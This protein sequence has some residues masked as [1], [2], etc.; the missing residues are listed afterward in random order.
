MYAQLIGTPGDTLLALVRHA[1]IGQDREVERLQAESGADAGAVRALLEGEHLPTTGDADV[2]D[3]IARAAGIAPQALGYQAAMT[4]AADGEQA[5]GG[6]RF[7]MSTASSDRYKD[8]LLQNWDVTN[9]MKAPVCPWMHNYW[10][11][12][13]GKWTD[14]AVSGAGESRSLKGT[15]IFDDDPE[16]EFAQKVASQYRRGFLGAVSVGF[17]PGKYTRR[18]SLDEDDPLFSK[19]GTIFD[20]LVLLEASAVTVPGN[21]EA[22]AIGRSMLGVRHSAPPVPPLDMSWLQAPE[23]ERAWL[24]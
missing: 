18:Y 11:L 12:P 4:R 20:D 17:L 14:V 5:E 23:E 13:V 2:L 3:A 6:M 10:G 19:R 8:I 15:L 7:V 9:F 22:V 16:H 24:W 1:D 21:G